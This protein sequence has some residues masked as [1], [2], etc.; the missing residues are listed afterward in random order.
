MSAQWGGF[1]TANQNGMVDLLPV[2]SLNRGVLWA[3]CD[4]NREGFKH[5]G[6]NNGLDRFSS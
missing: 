2:A 1:A 6:E 5:E 4:K 3:S